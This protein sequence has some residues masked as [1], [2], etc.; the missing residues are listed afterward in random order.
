[1]GVTE[2]PAP[3]LHCTPLAPSPADCVDLEMARG[4][5]GGLDRHEGSAQVTEGPGQALSA[6]CLPLTRKQFS[7]AELYL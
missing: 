1:M 4:G 6:R 3:W 7:Q 2:Q 5:G